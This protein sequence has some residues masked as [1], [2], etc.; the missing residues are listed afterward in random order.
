MLST[1]ADLIILLQKLPSEMSIGHIEYNLRIDTYENPPSLA[2]VGEE[3]FRQSILPT[4]Q[5]YIE[6]DNRKTEREQ[7]RN[8]ILAMWGKECWYKIEGDMVIV[9]NGA[10]DIFAINFDNQKLAVNIMF[11]VGWNFGVPPSDLERKNVL[12]E[13]EE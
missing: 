2:I 12:P 8:S 7:K 5:E 6:R 9:H 10:A 13:A 1:I 3:I 11:N 4:I